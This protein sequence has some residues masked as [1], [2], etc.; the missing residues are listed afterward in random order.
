MCIGYLDPCGRGEHEWAQE[1][2]A[3]FKHCK[4]CGLIQ[5]TVNEYEGAETVEELKA[6]YQ[7]WL[8]SLKWQKKAIQAGKFKASEK[9]KEVTD[10][11]I[12]LLEEYLT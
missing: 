9:L 3:N 8:R 11:M 7:H 2:P 12:Q 5:F 1:H 6:Q 4:K 10:R